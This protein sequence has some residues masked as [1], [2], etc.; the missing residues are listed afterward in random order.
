MRSLDLRVGRVWLGRDVL[1]LLEDWGPPEHGPCLSSS[2]PLFISIVQQLSSP[3]ELFVTI[4]RELRA[5]R[6]IRNVMRQSLKLR[7]KCGM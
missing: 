2:C 5:A 7:V 4:Y 6:D 1:S 3:G